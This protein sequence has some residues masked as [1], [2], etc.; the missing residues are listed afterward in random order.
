MSDADYIFFVGSVHKQY[1]LRSSINL[2]M[3]KIKPGKII[4][5]TIKRTIGRIFVT[6]NSHL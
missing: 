1:H 4:A 6:M 2:A 3:Y 5:E